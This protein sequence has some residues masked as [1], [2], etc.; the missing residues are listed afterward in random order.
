MFILLS[1]IFLFCLVIVCLILISAVWPPDA[2]WSPWW[3]TKR[4]IA[5]IMFRL[6]KVKK[7]DRIYDMGSGTGEGLITAVKEY[8]VRCVGIEIDPLRYLLS[9][10]H[11]RHAKVLDHITFIN[12]NFYNVDISDATVV[13]MYLVPKALRRLTTKLQ[14]ELKPGTRIICYRYPMPLEMYGG[15][16][17]LMAEEKE[18]KV[19]VY[20]M[21]K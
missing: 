8:G 9:K 16:L 3:T 10:W 11:A 7:T 14:S 4:D 20:E 1:N 18:N 17:K 21:K 6:A 2:P 12:N 19:Y 15:K 5:R 13:L